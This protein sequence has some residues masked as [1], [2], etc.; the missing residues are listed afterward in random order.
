MLCALDGERVAPVQQLQQLGAHEVAPPAAQGADVGLL[1][2]AAGGGD[3]LVEVR[4]GGHEL[5][6]QPRFQRPRADQGLGQGDQR[7]V[8]GLVQRR[9]CAVEGGRLGVPAAGDRVQQLGPAPAGDAAVQAADLVQALAVAGLAPPYD[10]D[11]ELHAVIAAI[12]WT[13][14]LQEVCR[15]AQRLGVDVQL[16]MWGK[17]VGLFDLKALDKALAGDAVAAVRAY[18]AADG[19]KLKRLEEALLA[20]VPTS[21][22]DRLGWATPKKMQMNLQEEDQALIYY[23]G[24]ACAWNWTELPERHSSAVWLEGAQLS[25]L[26]KAIASLVAGRV[27]EPLIDQLALDYG[28]NEHWIDTDLKGAAASPKGRIARSLAKLDALVDEAAKGGHKL[29]VYMAP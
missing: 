14:S 3:D 27:Q 23:L 22:E 20:A 17:V 13:S 12:S 25:P 29:L 1:V 9:P 6:G 18:Y 26:R 5:V 8:P 7:G 24:L 28:A 15:E 21:A 4:A 10:E 11:D 2:A 19:E 16:R